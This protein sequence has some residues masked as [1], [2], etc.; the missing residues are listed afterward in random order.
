MG[1]VEGGSPTEPG[2]SPFGRGEGLVIEVEAHDAQVGAGFQ[3]RLGVAST[4][5]C[6]IEHCSGRG[7]LEGIDHLSNHDRP[8][9]EVGGVTLFGHRC[10]LGLSP[11]TDPGPSIDRPPT[12]GCTS[13]CL[14][15]SGWMARRAEGD[16]PSC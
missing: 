4:P 15:E 7:S 2:Q 5:D 8:V 12:N 16:L 13:G 1:P 11:G 3:Y 10:L 9:F 6:G 14:P